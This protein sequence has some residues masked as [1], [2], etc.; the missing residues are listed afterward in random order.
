MFK[1]RGAWIVLTVAILGVALIATATPAQA[2]L[3]NFTSDHCT[4]TCGTAPFG[5]V[6]LT[7]NGTNVDVVVTL[8]DGSTFVKSGAGGFEAF[9][10]VGLPAGSGITL[11]AIT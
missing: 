7:Q 1:S 8:F 5:S 4:G 3:F 9:K 11:G 10:F 2:D 6:K